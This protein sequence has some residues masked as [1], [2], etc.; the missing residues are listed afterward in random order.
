MTRTTPELAPLLQTSAPHQ[1]EDFSPP[2]Y[3]LA[4][5]RPN[6]RRI[7]SG[8][9]FRT[10]NLKAPERSHHYSTAASRKLFCYERMN[11][12]VTCSFGASFEV[13]TLCNFCHISFKDVNAD[14]R[15]SFA[16][17]SI[18]WSLR[19]CGIENRCPLSKF[20]L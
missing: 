17:C 18:S 9:R 3:D 11:T 7:F 6:T 13:T 10:W 14:N 12:D 20:F 15:P 4:C 5:S 8:F 16:T 19:F 2:T 1:W